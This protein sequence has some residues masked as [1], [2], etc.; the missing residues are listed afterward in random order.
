MDIKYRTEDLYGEGFREAA[1]VMAFETFELNN[2]DIL[3]TLS[4]TILKDTE[5]G[6]QLKKMS[7]FISEEI[8][9]EE[10]NRMFNLYKEDEE[11]G[12]TFFNKV[13]N[14]INKITNKNIRYCLW[15]CDS[16]KDI[17]NQYYKVLEHNVREKD[18]YFDEYED[19]EIILSDLGSS[20]KLYGYESIPKPI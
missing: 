7:L 18:I 1:S 20:G 19:S 16:K 13:L 17:I 14:E 6:K 11:V 8:E 15:L 12:I 3:D 2:T 10:L 5:I 4:K 9:D